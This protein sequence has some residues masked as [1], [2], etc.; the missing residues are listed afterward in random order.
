MDSSRE[1]RVVVIT[2]GAGGIGQAIARRYL[3]AG[4]RIALV[5]RDLDALEIARATLDDY[6]TTHQH[7][8]T[9]TGRAGE[10]IDTVLAAHGQIDILVHCAGLT[11][12]S[13]C[14]DTTLEVYRRVMEVNFFGA[15]A[16]T[17]AALLALVASRGHIVV[18]SSVAG[19]APLIGRTGYCAAKHA[20]HGF[21]ETLRAELTPD[22][23]GVTIVCPTFTATN[24]A[25]AGLTGD[26]SQLSFDRSTS[27]EIITPETVAE[28]IFRAVAGNKPFTFPGRTAK[29]A[30]WF[31]RVAPHTY[32]RIMIRRF[33]VE[34][35]RHP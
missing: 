33:A 32:V 35:K 14:C 17:Q 22:G 12:V 5:D 3:K 27:G 20:L 11:Q 7:D 31:R 24:F 19:F 15:V 28:D 30:W 8:V 2:G 13:P 25:R 21:F 10:L 4:C 1:R 9:Q 34:L 26:G 29:L 16:L 23:V 18:L 6:V